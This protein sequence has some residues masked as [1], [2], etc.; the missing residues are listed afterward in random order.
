MVSSDLWRCTKLNVLPKRSESSD[1]WNEE[2]FKKIP[3]P[4]SL[5]SD[6]FGRTFIFDWVLG[7]FAALT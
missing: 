6:R 5:D 1:P 2:K 4:G 3:N 7:D